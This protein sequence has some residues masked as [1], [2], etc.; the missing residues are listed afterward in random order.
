MGT[1]T[2]H[3]EPKQLGDIWRIEFT[4]ATGARMT[5]VANTRESAM[6]IVDVIL[7]RQSDPEQSH[8]QDEI[9]SLR[10]E[11]AEARHDAAMWER[12]AEDMRNRLAEA[13]NKGLEEAAQ[14]HDG[15]AA[16]YRRQIFDTYEREEYHRDSAVLVKP[17]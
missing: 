9:T 12:N 13:R 16:H 6:A 7:D 1:E 15:K 3:T 4:T 2:K 11:L 10:K 14:W 17:A 5:F 8:P